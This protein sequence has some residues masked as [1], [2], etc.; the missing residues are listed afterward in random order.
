MAD[1][2]S[3]GPV[4]GTA[5]ACDQTGLLILGASG[6]GKSS[7]ALELVALGAG[8]V[9]DDRVIC[10]SRDGGVLMTAPRALEHR[11]EARGLGILTVPTAP[12]F[13]RFVVDLD[14]S[15][16]QRFPEPRETVIKGVSFP[17]FQRVES[18][19]FASM[20]MTLLR[21]GIA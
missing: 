9:A 19:A 14:V 10:T 8:L 16:T 12:A 5:V 18:P 15:E 7:L 4:H 21:G 20:L 3:T 2:H 11:I 13:L 6:A 17:L 1:G